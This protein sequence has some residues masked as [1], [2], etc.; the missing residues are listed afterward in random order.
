MNNSILTGRLTDEIQLRKTQTDKSWCRFTLACN[1]G[2]KDKDNKPI[3]DFVNVIAWEQKADFLSNFAHKGYMVGA[4]GRIETR[5][6]EKDGV[7]HYDTYVLADY[8]EILGEPR[9]AKP[10]TDL[11]PSEI[12]DFNDN[13]TEDDFGGYEP[14]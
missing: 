7:K 2:A 14:W 5:T 3:V 12:N 4:K 8:V 9:G 1:R 13:F 6:Y 10:R 11:K